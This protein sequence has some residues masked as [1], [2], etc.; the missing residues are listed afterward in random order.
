MKITIIAGARPNFIKIAPIIKAI[1][2]KQAEGST[3][4]YRLVHTGQHYDKNLSDTFFEELNIPQPHANLEV[5][6]GSQA[7]QTA[8]IM[9]AFE[10]ELIQHPCDLVLVVGDVNSTMACAIVAKKLNVKV[11]HVEAGIRSGDMT[12]PEEINR[13]VTDSIT[14]YFFTTSTTASD[15]LLKY[16]AESSNIHFVGNVMIDTLYQN[17]NRISAPAFWN[18]FGLE[19]GNYII[20]TLHRPANVDE[21]KSLVELLQGIDKM[22]GDKKIIFPIHPRTKAILGETDLALKN[23]LF[24][25]PQGYLNFMF[26][27]QNSFAVIT[28]SGGIS[29]ETTVL[30]IPCFTMR[31]NTERPETQTIGTNTLVGT[32]IE[33]LEKVFA[34]FLQN[35]QR[36][37][38]IPELWDGK[39]S[40][41]IIAILLKK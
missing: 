3:V 4:S 39:A 34:E 32:S 6:S 5:K 22:V 23:I 21:E 10:N 16:G 25:E 9:M 12:M 15:N 20:L 35:G 29:E 14:D 8:A 41:R 24:V 11:A 31:N 18:E 40:E 28:D 17:L 26:L 37:S 33:N 2:K 19:T 36:K 1:E 38:G 7:Q 30:N 13:I 27:I